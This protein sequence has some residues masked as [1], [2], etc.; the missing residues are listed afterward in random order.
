M[1]W[2]NTDADFAL[3]A[4]MIPAFSFVPIEEL[5]NALEVLSENLPNQLNPILD[6]FENY[7]VGRS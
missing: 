1:R 3:C 6:Y 2:H 4:R 5:E 7:Y